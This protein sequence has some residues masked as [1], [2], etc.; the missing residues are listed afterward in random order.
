MTTPIFVLGKHRSGTTWLA[1]QLCQHSSIVGVQ[2]EAHHGIHESAYFST[3]C[4]RYGDVANRSNFIELVEVLGASDYFRLAGV[5]KEYLYSLW[6]TTY[7][8]LFRAAMDRFAQRDDATHWLEKT[9]THT[10]LVSELANF[11]PDARFVSVVREVEAVVRSTLAM[12]AGFPDGGPS[13]RRRRTGLIL[14]TV[15]SWAYYNK[16]VEAFA[17]RSNRALRLGYDSMTTDLPGTLHRVC[18]FLGLDFEQG[19]CRPAYAPNT[20]FPSAGHRTQAL[21]KEECSLARLTALLATLVPLPLLRETRRLKQGMAGRQPL[22]PWF[23]RLHARRHSI[24]SWQTHATQPTAPRHRPRSQEP[25]VSAGDPH[26]H[27]RHG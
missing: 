13:V 18:G 15:F 7:E 27:P 9:P 11:Y 12:M 17:D 14:R 26:S 10:P 2:H 16:A 20:S 6:P 25:P 23:F 4:N 3:I 1:N 24:S 19:M 5:S 8:N 22:P 21:S